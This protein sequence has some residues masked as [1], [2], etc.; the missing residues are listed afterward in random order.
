MTVIVVAFV[1]GGALAGYVAWELRRKN[2][3]RWILPYLAGRSRRRL[4]DA[5]DEVHVLLCIADH[6]EP[7]GQGGDHETARRRVDIWVREYPRRFGRFRDSDGRAPRHTFFYPAEEY[8]PDLLE[9]LADLC[10]QG[11]G[12]VEI[13]LHHD[14]D[15]AADFRRKIETFKSCLTERH[16]LLSCD[17]KTGAI[18]YGF[19]HGNWALCNARRDGRLCG[20]DGELA[21]LH[22]TGCYA[23]FTYP[24]APDETQPPIVNRIYYA[25]DRPGGPRSHETPCEP[26]AEG[27]V[28]MIQGP[29]VLD[30][31]NRKLGLIPR[32]ENGCIQETQPADVR[33]I[34]NWL[35]ARV[36]VSNRPDWH[37]V[38]LHA[39][40]AT[41]DAHAALL[42]PTMEAFHAAL[43]ERARANPKFHYHY[44]TA[45]EMYNLARAA[46]DGFTGR[47]AEALDYELTPAGKPAPV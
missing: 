19:I 18:R 10:R 26:D 31:S 43:A 29:L 30:W 14:G 40:G 2:M 4:P 1:L 38:K 24:S 36:Q 15:S 42:G 44:V 39:H 11:F 13:H 45:R 25:C 17:R 41:E 5:T 6:Y 35:R 3:R 20:V 46:Q 28:M 7:K 23:D 33:R 21:I 32:L 27:A 34:D 8:E 16:G 12:E 47:V 9:R 22:E 37:F